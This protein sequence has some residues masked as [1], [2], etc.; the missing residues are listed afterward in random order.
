MEYIESLSGDNGC[1]LCR[2]REATENDSENFVLW[3]GQR[4]FVVLNRFPYTNGHAMVAPLAH[5][6]TLADL[7]TETMCELT[8][9]VRDLQGVLTDVVHAD[10]FNI[11]MNI[12]RCAGAGLPDHLHVHVVPRWNGDTNF[13]PVFGEVRVIPM[14]LKSLYGKLREASER[15]RPPRSTPEQR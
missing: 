5:I 13:M 3:R 8:A 14:S 1:F 11:G 7:D 9:M 4:C 15:M 12:G 6:A 2:Y 10:G